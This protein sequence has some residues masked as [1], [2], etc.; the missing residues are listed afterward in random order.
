MSERD[1]SE[2]DGE[3]KRRHERKPVTL[4]VEYEGADDLVADFTENLSSGGTYVQAH[5]RSNGTYVSGYVRGS[6]GGSSRSG[7]GGRS[8]RSGGGGGGKGRR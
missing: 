3:N 7:G 1:N 5:Y 8:G 4:V 2:G 6:G